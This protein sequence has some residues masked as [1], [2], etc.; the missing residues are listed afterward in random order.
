[1][2]KPLINNEDEWMAPTGQVLTMCVIHEL[3]YRS[4]ETRQALTVIAGFAVCREHMDGVIEYICDGT[5]VK[6][7]IDEA[8]R[9][10]F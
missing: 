10:E 9:G 7:I 1:M 3:D 2:R 4:T 8:V 6:N 5:S